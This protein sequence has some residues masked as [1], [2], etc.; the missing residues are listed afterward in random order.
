[1][2]DCSPVRT[3]G[4][5]IE[6]KVEPEGNVPLSIED[7]IGYQSIPGSLIFLYPCTRVDIWLAVSQ[8]AQFIATYISSH[9]GRKVHLV[10][11]LRHTRTPHHLQS[12]QQL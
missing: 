9:G 10:L 3:P 8:A 12:Q 7:T 2:V 5:G 4:T 6:L 11:P 1:M